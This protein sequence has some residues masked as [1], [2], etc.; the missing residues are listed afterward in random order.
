MSTLS[1]LSDDKVD[2]LTW[3][4]TTNEE[5]NTDTIANDPHPT[6]EIKG[7]LAIKNFSST[8]NIFLLLTDKC[9]K[10]VVL[11]SGSNGRYF[12]L[13]NIAM[14]S[15]VDSAV[16]SLAL[17]HLA[18][19]STTACFV[20][21][22]SSKTYYL[23]NPQVERPVFLKG[24]LPSL[25]SNIDS[26][27][28]FARGIALLVVSQN[29]TE[30]HVCNNKDKSCALLPVTTAQLTTISQLKVSDD[31]F[32]PKYTTPASR[33]STRTTTSEFSASD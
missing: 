18:C 17:D 15:E 9:I 5:P 28:T 7:I 3:V 2:K 30:L 1:V 24:E 14:I 32:S 4:S 12:S 25:P 26:I 19:Y 23:F 8:E 31:G 33:S 22:F 27:H 16:S 13:A 21:S 6:Q 29:K 20:Y 11:V 10:F